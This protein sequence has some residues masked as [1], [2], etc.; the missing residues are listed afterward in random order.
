MKKP[1]KKERGG[2]AEP[3]ENE[4]TEGGRRVGKNWVM[5]LKEAIEEHEELTKVGKSKSKK[6][7]KEE[8]S[9]QRQELRRMKNSA[10]RSLRDALPIK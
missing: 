3:G 10:G 1:M 8:M 4:A 5:P 2:A 9:E 7:D 6:D